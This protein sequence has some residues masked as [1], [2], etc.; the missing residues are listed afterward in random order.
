M[1]K[2][3]HLLSGIH[4]SIV[5]AH[6]LASEQHILE[7]KKH[8]ESDGKTLKMMEF[9]LKENGGKIRIQVPEITLV[10]PRSLAIEKVIV[11]MKLLFDVDGNQDDTGKE[12]RGSRLIARLLGTNDERRD[13]AVEV[14][15]EFKG[16]QPPEGVMRF[17]EVLDQ[18]VKIT[19]A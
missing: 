14:T 7:V 18:M 8:L 19:K 15:V 16:E 13:D 11:K 9:E 5:A 1:D 12:R 17:R 4:T 6:H 2:L 10:P 3:D